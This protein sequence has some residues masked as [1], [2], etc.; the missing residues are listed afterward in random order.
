MLYRHYKGG[1][2]RVIGDAVHTETEEELV[3]YMSVE[4]GLIWVRPSE[5]FYEMI[6]LPDGRRSVARFEE[7][8]E[9]LIR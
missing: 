9:E 8:H 5:M 3:V 2:Y 6:D 7:V 1:L 4:T